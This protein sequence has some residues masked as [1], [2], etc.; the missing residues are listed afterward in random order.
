MKKNFTIL[1]CALLSAL[2]TFAQNPVPTHFDECVELMAAVWRLSGAPEYNRCMVP[3][4]AHEVD[5]VFEP[6]KEHPVVQLARQYPNETG[7]GYD[8]IASYGLHLTLT[9]NGTIVLND[10]FLEGSD[11][12]FD[13]WS[14]QQK[15]EFLAPLNDFYRTSR[16]HDWFLRQHDFYNRLKRRSTPST[17]KSITTGS[18]AISAGKAAAHSVSCSVCWWVRTTTDAVPN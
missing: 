5:S 3:Q 1:F 8:A 15:K 9:E 4:Y 18:T 12:S 7:I 6:F 14:D 2:T 16:F 13:R 10:S 17:N 11:D